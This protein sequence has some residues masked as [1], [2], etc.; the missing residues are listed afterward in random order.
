[1][2]TQNDPWSKEKLQLTL[3]LP[4]TD[5]NGVDLSA[6]VYQVKQEVLAITGG[7]TVVQQ[8]EGAWLDNNTGRTYYDGMQILTTTFDA[9]RKDIAMKLR[10][11]VRPWCDLL[12]QESL[13]TLLSTVLDVSQASSEALATYD[14]VTR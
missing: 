3:Q 14:A 9:D 10:N 6:E 11:K 13:Y 2:A 5:N 7:Y 1:M 4:Y 12:R 8:A